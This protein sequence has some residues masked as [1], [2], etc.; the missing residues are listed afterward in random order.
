MTDP[1]NSQ[2]SVG[3]GWALVIVVT[4]DV[5]RLMKILCGFLCGEESQAGFN[6]LIFRGDMAEAVSFS[7]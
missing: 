3:R 4:I 6:L 5:M 2:K 7:V 1:Q